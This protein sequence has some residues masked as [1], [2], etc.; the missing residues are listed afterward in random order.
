MVEVS[1]KMVFVVRS[2]DDVDVVV[3]GKFEVT[4]VL[5]TLDMRRVRAMV[6][7]MVITVM[8]TAVIAT[9]PIAIASFVGAALRN[10]IR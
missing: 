1:W 10:I 7:G 8:T 3:I 2:V 9:A 6:I 5:E 4:D